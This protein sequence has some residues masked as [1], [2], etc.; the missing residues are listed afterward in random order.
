METKTP[1]VFCPR[2]GAKAINLVQCCLVSECPACG[3]KFSLFVP[4]RESFSIPLDVDLGRQSTAIGLNLLWLG[5]KNELYCLDFSNKVSNRMQLTKFS[6]QHDWLVNGLAIAG[7]HIVFSPGESKPFGASKALFGLDMQSGQVVWEFPSEG[8]AF[9]RPAVDENLACAVDSN[10]TLVA[11]C[12]QDGKP[13]WE[14]FPNLG[15]YPRNSIPPVLSDN[16]VL[17]VDSAG[18]LCAFHRESGILT[19]TFLP[20]DGSPLDFE[21][22]VYQESVFVLAGSKLYRVFIRDGRWE[23]LFQAGRQSSMGWYFSPP[24]VDHQRILLLEAC[25]NDEQKPAYVLRALNPQNGKTLWQHFLDRHPRQPPLL[26]GDQV[27]FID[28]H[29]QMLCLD[30]D[31]GTIHWQ[32]QLDNEPA[33]P[34]LIFGNRLI[35]ITRKASLYAFELSAPEISIDEPAHNYLNRGEWQLAAGAFLLANQPLQAGLALMQAG[36]WLQA[37]QAFALL[38]EASGELTALLAQ[39]EHEKIDAESAR[40]C[41]ALARLEMER[42]GSQARGEKAI[43]ERW[44]QAASHYLTAQDAENAF[45]CR[46][47]AA[48]VMETPRFHMVVT[49]S[50]RLLTRQA[51]LLN[52]QLEN[53]GYGGARQVRIRVSGKIKP[54]YQ[55]HKFSDLLVG[56]PQTWNTACIVPLQEGSLVLDIKLEYRNYRSDEIGIA[57]FEHVIQVER[58]MSKDIASALKHGATVTIDKFFSPGA[59]HNKIEIADSQQIFIGDRSNTDQEKENNMDPVTIVI[60]A[61]VGG[62]TAGVSE[63]AK[64]AVQD[65]YNALKEQLAKKVAPQPEAQQALENVIKTPES[66]GHQMVLAEELEKLDIALDRKLMELAKELLKTIEASQGT[67]P[68]YQVHVQDSQVGVIGDVDNLTQNFG[69]SPKSKKR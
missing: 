29:G 24:V 60:S 11:V 38:P 32:E 39:S 6:T 2:C 19:W 42:L 64:S 28:R 21:P 10:G 34:P 54:P 69:T 22:V 37:R 45:R 53:Q 40:I 63:T 16:L 27:Y 12:P 61:I 33:A 56:Q 50:N 18:K 35:V 51:S 49:S 52:I 4:L 68:K 66:K 23:Q 5:R 47:E 17:A 13:A 59:T 55:E 62:L 58:D 14:E 26:D 31:N 65:M 8:F 7:N 41:V 48:K 46:E 20:P 9:T 44:E 67:S 25:W 43:A 36:D 1:F 3:K 15:D 30:A 57:R